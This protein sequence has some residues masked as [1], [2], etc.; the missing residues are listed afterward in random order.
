MPDE[1]IRGTQETGAPSRT[2]PP[3]GTAGD[4]KGVERT[5]RAVDLGL[6][7]LR[8]RWRTR[9][10]VFIV[11]ASVVLLLIGAGM[12]YWRLNAGL[13]KTDN[14]QTGGDLAPVSAQISGTVIKIDVADNQYVKSGTV[15]VEIDPTDYRLALDQAKANLAAAEA[16]VRVAQATLADQENQYRTGVNAARGALAAT[17]PRLPQAQAQAQFQQAQAGDTLVRERAQQLAAAEAQAAATAQA[18][19]TAQVNLDRTLIR[20]PADGWVTNRTAQIGQ[21]V[22]PN[23]PLLS[24]AIAEHRWIVANIK[25]T[26]LANVQVGDPARITVDVF[27]G[28]VF[29]GHV[30]SIT[31]ASGS[32]TAL[33]PPDNATGNFV[34]VVQL[35]AVRISLDPDADPDVHVP[36]GVSAEVTIDTRHRGR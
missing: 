35:V 34:K 24:V 2:A 27:R 32:A 6:H 16:Q 5:E 15:L 1:P 26:Q 3:G 25:E 10:I 20:A 21:T 18:V 14:A 36:V 23:Q 13:V 17:T 19:K 30:L 9:R 8:P 22:Q 12:A 31:A 7:T 29:H 4:G 33:L 11:L 28:R